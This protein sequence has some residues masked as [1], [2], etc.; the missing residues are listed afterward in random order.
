MEILKDPASNLRPS[1]LRPGEIT[2]DLSMETPGKAIHQT[3]PATSGKIRE[4]LNDSD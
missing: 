2:L 3:L 1:K 4:T